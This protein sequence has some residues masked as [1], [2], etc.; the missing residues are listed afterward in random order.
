ML[1]AF[2]LQQHIHHLH[3]PDSWNNKLD[4]LSLAQDIAR[5]FRLLVLEAPPSRHRC[6]DNKRPSKAAAFFNHLAD[7]HAI[8]LPA[9]AESQQIAD[10][11]GATALLRSRW[12]H[13]LR[14]GPAVPG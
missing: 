4:T 1:A 3:R 14:D 5:V 2:I 11:V 8:Q 6:I 12:G 7:P 10:H 9:L 13:E